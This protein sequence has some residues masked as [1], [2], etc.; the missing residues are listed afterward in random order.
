MR[1]AFFFMV[2][3]VV[4]KRKDYNI[5]MMGAILLVHIG[6]ILLYPQ[7]RV[8]LVVGSA[9]VLFTGM[10]LCDRFLHRKGCDPENGPSSL[11]DSFL[12]FLPFLLPLYTYDVPQ[13][14]VFWHFDAVGKILL[15]WFLFSFFRLRRANWPHPKVT[16][17]IAFTSFILFLVWTSLLWLNLTWDVGAR[18][19]QLS[20]SER[21]STVI[22]KVWEQRPFI[23]HFGLAFV[24]WESFDKSAY[25]GHSQAYLLILYLFVRL[26]R[27]MGGVSMEE[28][29]RMIAFF[30]AAI[31]VGSVAYAAWASGRARI[32]N[33]LS[34]QLT[35]F[36]GLGFLLSLP[37]FW[38]TLL[39]YCMDNPLPMI[40]CFNLILLTHINLKDYGLF[41]V[42]ILCT[43]C[44]LFP[45]FGILSTIALFFYMYEDCD[46]GNM[47]KKLGAAVLMAFF[48]MLYPVM[49]I[50]VLGYTDTSSSLLFRSG[51][52]GDTSYYTNIFQ[53]VVFPFNA[54][55]IRPWSALVPS[56]LFALVTLTIYTLIKNR[57]EK[58]APLENLL[59]IF[60]PYFASLVIAPQSVSIH[61]Y[62]YDYFI[63]FPATYLAM[64]WSLSEAF[65][66]SIR[67]PRMY[68]WLLFLSGLLVNNLTKIAQFA[69]NV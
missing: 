45:R 66:D 12:L 36:F 51:L 25:S 11:R 64:H 44:L 53:A 34:A 27:I 65:Q 10:V 30:Y 56:L 49:V 58:E 62:L 63:L 31:L 47:I 5:W 39:K 54:G 2:S 7:R 50:K 1:R 23:E 26:V 21:L 35:L 52:D 24:N 18:M 40:I 14:I 28:A 20:A 32:L 55:Q 68:G 17:D 6:Y 57:S 67:G 46:L 41:F 60:V 3:A 33:R 19:L 42:G 69:R 29:T 15:A 38:I 37:D 16:S 22:Y 8:I 59:F 13:F 43:Y 48:S 4:T 9:L 61:P